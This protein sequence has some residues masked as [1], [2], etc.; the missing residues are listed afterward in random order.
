MSTR[1][2]FP[3]LFFGP[4]V[5]ALSFAAPAFGQGRDTV[6]AV[7]KLF[8][9]KRGGAAGYSEA[10]AST[11]SPT[12][13][14]AQRANGRLTSQ[15]TRQDLLA[16]AAFGAVGMVKG[17]RYSAQREAAIID[18]YALGNPIPADIR[19]KLRRKYFHRT[20]QDLLLAR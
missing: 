19:V 17:A 10:A 5:A 9:A 3:L 13:Y 1:K 6:F 4:L 16:G 8:R 12:R 18:G 7:H 14:A 15:G 2:R 11:T 20:A